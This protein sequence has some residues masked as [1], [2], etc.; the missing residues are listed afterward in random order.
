[1]AGWRL[2]PQNVVGAILVPIFLWSIGAAEKSGICSENGKT[3]PQSHPDVRSERHGETQTKK[4]KTN[5]IEKNK[6]MWVRKKHNMSVR[7]K[8]TKSHIQVQF[9]QKF[10]KKLLIYNCLF[11]KC[12]SNDEIDFLEIDRR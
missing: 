11:E 5:A 10:N 7:K 12:Y 9:P 3:L 2:Y 8:Q 1:M 4:D 6:T